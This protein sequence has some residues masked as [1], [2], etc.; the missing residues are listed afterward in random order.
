[1]KHLKR[2]RGDVAGGGGRAG[3]G[4][5]GTRAGVEG[6]TLIE[7]LVALGVVA[8]IA[9]GITQVFTLTSETVRQGRR[10]S[11]LI[12]S[13]S[14]IERQL[15]ADFG[16]MTR[17]GFMVIRHAY[18]D[19]NGD[20]TITAP[21]LG[22]L[23]TPD[24]IPASRTD[25]RPRLRRI[26]ELVF[27]AKGEFTSA[28]EPRHVSRNASAGEARIYYGH[29]L[30][31]LPPTST[32]DNE[33]VRPRLNDDNPP[34]R[35]PGFGVTGLSVEN[36]NR[37]A[38]DWTL[39]RHVTLLAQ[40]GNGP[41]ASLTPPPPSGPLSDLTR[42]ADG[43]RQIGLQPA[44]QSIFRSLARNSVY[45][46]GASS[47]LRNVPAPTTTNGPLFSSGVVDIA[48]TSLAEIR[49][50][51]LSAPPPPSQQE[52]AGPVNNP[53]NA[54]SRLL[55]FRGG[56]EAET[57]WPFGPS[58]APARMRMQRWMMDALPGD[59]DGRD[60]SQPYS[61]GT[62]NA[63]TRMRY[64]ASP[65]DLFD[66]ARL[67]VVSN[68]ERDPSVLRADQLMVASSVFVPR[69][70]D[71]VVEWSFGSVD[72]QPQPGQT[73]LPRR[74]D[75]PTVGRTLWHGLR[76]LV[77]VNGNGVYDQDVDFGVLPYP[78]V[79]RNSFGD[80][81]GPDTSWPSGDPVQRFRQEYRLN[82]GTTTTREVR[83][84][85]IHPSFD[86]GN[87]NQPTV[88][89]SM[90]SVFGFIDPTYAPQRPVALPSDSVAVPADVREG[91]R[92]YANELQF[93]ADVLR[94][95][96]NPPVPNAAPP[97]NE[98]TFDPE[99]GD[100]L[101]DPLTVPWAW[102]ALLRITVTL[103]DAVDPSVQ[104]TFEFVIPVPAADVGAP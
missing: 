25:S 24:T 31:Q 26:D 77:D 22:S 37:F 34:S 88:G 86:T 47:L 53:A 4:G 56:D 23:N 44:A 60:T 90:Y 1:M 83:E 45:S 3:R 43:V 21:S 92:G 95:D 81:T 75:S 8:L 18:A 7:L 15:R 104:Q 41:A 9:V 12:Q 14:L 94:F 58:A 72:N 103:A 57:Y 102:P 30:R 62:A 17:D 33:F 93:N 98:V 59:S 84:A 65:P 36:P 13:A 71:F 38:G 55:T 68:P 10:L 35:A 6:F 5:R 28:R 32:G 100:R 74:S 96:A 97:G 66:R 54:D 64:E 49:A 80:P 70:T 61:A 2:E 91:R 76:R 16:R 63:A 69:C 85:L 42:T 89:T 48:T 73:A 51:V 67:A 19:P 99:Q 87:L 50:I 39:L 79:F 11:N 20:G 101:R 52:W 78:R 46:G 82:D 29:G 40:P 27:F